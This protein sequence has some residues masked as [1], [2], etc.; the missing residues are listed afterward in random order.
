M[1]S[2]VMHCD[3]CRDAGTVTIE[4]AGAP[5]YPQHGEM[6]PEGFERE[7]CARQREHALTG[8]AATRPPRSQ[9]QQC[10]GIKLKN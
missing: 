7:G 1:V 4:D 5:L 2:G 10:S 3:R 8:R 9:K 6:T